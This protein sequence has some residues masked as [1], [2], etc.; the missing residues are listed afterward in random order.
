MAERLQVRGSALWGRKEWIRRHRGQ[1]GLEQLLP[2]LS[3]AGRN[4]LRSEIDPGAWYNYP[5]FLDLA[6]ALDRRFGDGDY[7]LN[8]EI[9]RFGAHHNTPKLYSLF[10]RLGSVDWV[11]NRAAKLWREHFNAGS[12]VIHTEKG[13]PRAEA[14]IIDWPE[15]HLAHSYSVVG[16]AH[17]VIE[18]SGAKNV[19]TEL[20]SC[21][22]VGGE[23]TRLRARWDE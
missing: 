9:G 2:D 1:E 5:L 16:F 18:L 8:V 12:L 7:K 11:L 6:V 20:V 21:R 4:V 3:P 19:V 10:I 22:S 14:E 17:G 13:A 23:T 15:P